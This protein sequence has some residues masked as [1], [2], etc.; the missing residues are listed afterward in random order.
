MVKKITVSE[1][2]VAYQDQEEHFFLDVRTEDEF[3][4]G[5]IARFKNIPVDDLHNRVHEVPKHKTVVVICQAGV[6]SAKAAALLDKQGFAKVLDYTGSFAEWAK[7]GKPVEQVRKSTIT[8]QRQIQ[9]VA[10]TL[11]FTGI[12]LGYY[13]NVGFYIL[14]A[15]V[16]AGMFLAGLTGRCPMA[17][18]LSLMPWNKE[19]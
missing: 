13:V 15:A 6:R 17:L 1:F 7:L 18:V 12:V 16:S 8:I 10:G 9:L 11:G 5:F 4:S 14:A 3:K 19:N 2:E